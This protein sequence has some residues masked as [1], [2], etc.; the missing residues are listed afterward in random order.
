MWG[1]QG[2]FLT[3]NHFAGQGGCSRIRA[4][5]HLPLDKRNL[6]KKKKKNAGDINF[7]ATDPSR[8]Y[9]RA[10]PMLYHNI[11]ADNPDSTFPPPC[12][13]PFAVFTLLKDVI[14]I[15][16]FYLEYHLRLSLFRMLMS[17]AF[18]ANYRKDDKYLS[19]QKTPPLP[20]SPELDARVSWSKSHSTS[21]LNEK[22]LIK[23]PFN[24]ARVY[25]RRYFW[26]LLAS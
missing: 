18:Y 1:Q 10:N 2:L 15:L 17:H 4:P 24:S 6:D 26:H 22:L 3:W 13:L 5:H 23:S 9:K 19:D 14:F 25:M 11:G 7:K 16:F 20:L 8:D 12:L 21:T